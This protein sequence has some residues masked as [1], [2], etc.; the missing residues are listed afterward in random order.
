MSPVS[1]VEA[2]SK[3]APIPSPAPGGPTSLAGIRAKVEAGERL[4]FE[5]GVEL[6]RS[7]DLLEIGRLADSVR[8]RRWGQKAFYVVNRHLNP[9]NV[10]FAGCRFCA[11]A[12]TP[13]QPGAWTWTPEQAV[14]K[15]AET[16]A[17][18]GDEVTELHIVGGL[19]PELPLS[20]YTDLLRG[21]KT[22]FPRLHL[23]AF[24]AVELEFLCEISGLGIRE[25]LAKLVE[26]GLESL[27]G[28][29]AEIFADRVRDELCANKIYGDRWLEIHEIAHS[30]GLKSTSTMLY[31][32]VE[33]MEERVDHMV[34]L[35]ESQDRTGGYTAFIPLSFHPKDT[36][37][38]HLP[39]PSG[40]DDLK[41]LAVSRLMLDN[42]PHIKVYWVM[43]GMKIA[44][45]GLHFGADDIDGTVIDERITYAAGAENA[46][47]V[48]RSELCRLVREAGFVPVQRDTLYNE[49][50][51]D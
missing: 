20:Y 21:L 33:T 3:S 24:T 51:V 44:Q 36:E 12:R 50:R 31:G 42:F 15:A 46:R 2:K 23:K 19:H 39:G 18:W 27:P 11:F 5:D 14:E 38:A 1:P 8:R 37:L 6:F 13:D 35:R 26:A 41:T 34:R 9:T 48:D 40:Y 22:R 17:T 4:S 45:L 30:M 47:G 29:G 28:G 43:T 7:H 16:M 25:V 32:H 10:C 49:L